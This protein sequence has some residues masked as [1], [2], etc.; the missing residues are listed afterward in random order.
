MKKLLVLG[1]TLALVAFLAASLSA[2][3]RKG[4][5][6]ADLGGVLTLPMGDFGDAFKMGWRAGANVGYFVTDQIQIGGTGAYSQNKVDDTTGVGDAKFNIWQFGA[7]GKYMFKMQNPTIAPYVRAG[8]SMYSGKVS[9]SG[10]SSASSTDFGINGGLGV[11]FAVSP[12][13]SVFV[14]GAYHNIFTD[15]TSTN[16]LAANAGLSLMF[17]KPTPTSSRTR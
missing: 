14:E 11:S 10:S 17:G 16:Y 13:A 9:V 4:M 2:T 7:F 6:G 12:T 3:E 15:V 5:F 1:V 8:L